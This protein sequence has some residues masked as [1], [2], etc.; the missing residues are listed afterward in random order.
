M[1]YEVV[2]TA[3][4]I[5]AAI[6]TICM[7]NRPDYDPVPYAHL[8]P[9]IEEPVPEP[10]EPNHKPVIFYDLGDG[11]IMLWSSDACPE[12]MVV[13]EFCFS[14]AA[15]KLYVGVGSMRM[16]ISTDSLVEYWE[17]YHR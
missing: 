14:P 13:N 17:Q 10:M 4:I 12:P 16:P 3:L 11:K 15:G 2:V 6:I 8:P 7:I 9:V 1:K 5:A